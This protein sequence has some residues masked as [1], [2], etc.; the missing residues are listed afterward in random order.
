MDYNQ[1]IQTLEQARAYYEAMNCSSFHM[2][3]EEPQRYEEFRS[4]RISEWTLQQWE[5]EYMEKGIASLT[6]A[7][8]PVENLWFLHSQLADVVCSLFSFRLLAQ[9]YEATLQLQ[10]RLTPFDRLLVAETIVGRGE[11]KHK[12]GLIFRCHQML[13]YGLAKQYADLT[14]KLGSE[15]FPDNEV[16]SWTGDRT[17]E[18]RLQLLAK[19]ERVRA[20]CAWRIWHYPQEL[21]S[22]L[23]SKSGD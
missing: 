2:T 5:R 16:N 1:P 11:V 7:D 12:S 4:L 9:F 21:L 15:P 10:T 19:L 6:N 3:R 14:E 20:A 8:T 17:E 23:F 18:R 13:R 22:R